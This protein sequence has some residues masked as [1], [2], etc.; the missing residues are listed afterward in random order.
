MRIKWVF[1]KGSEYC[2]SQSR[3]YTGSSLVI[4]VRMT[5][6][7]IHSIYYIHKNQNKLIKLCHIGKYSRSKLSKEF[8][9]M[10][11]RTKFKFSTLSS[12]SSMIWVLSIHPIHLELLTPF[13]TPG[14][15]CL[16]VYRTHQYLLVLSVL[17][18]TPHPPDSFWTFRSW[19]ESQLPRNV[20]SDHPT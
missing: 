11:Q 15:K 17:S 16:L 1:I 19:L 3:C 9:L 5:M 12:M 2:V 7:K 13:L 8:P 18:S 14:S 6:M 4:M 10:T 20:S